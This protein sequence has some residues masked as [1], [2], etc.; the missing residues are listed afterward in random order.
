M[1]TV[2]NEIK[3]I[4]VCFQDLLT[5]T[6]GTGRLLFDDIFFGTADVEEKDTPTNCSC[7]Q[8]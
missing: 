3:T 1:I 8:S 7:S 6:N 4:F 5:D 2:A